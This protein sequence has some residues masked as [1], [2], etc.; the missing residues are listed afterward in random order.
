[1][2][3]S[4]CPTAIAFAIEV[5]AANPELHARFTVWNEL[6]SGIPACKLAIRPALLP[7]SSERTDVGEE[8]VVVG[9][10]EAAFL[11]AGDGRA[12]G[13]EEDDVVGVLLEDVFGAFLEEGHFEGRSPCC[14][15]GGMTGLKRIAR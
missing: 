2:P 13:G 7:P 6:V 1:M 8:F 9:V 5:I 14:F 11:C 15:A 12:E 3:T 4:I 10:F